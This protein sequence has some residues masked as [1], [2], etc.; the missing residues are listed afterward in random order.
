MVEKAA[1][2]I[3]RGGH[4][5]ETWFTPVHWLTLCIVGSLVPSGLLGFFGSRRNVGSAP[6]SRFAQ[7]L[8][9]TRRCFGSLIPLGYRTTVSVLTHHSADAHHGWFSLVR[10]LALPHR[11]N[12]TSWL[13]AYVLVLADFVAVAPAFWFTRQSWLSLRDFGSRTLVGFRSLS[14][15]LAGSLASRVAVGSFGNRGYAPMCWFALLNWLRSPRLVHSLPLASP[16]SSGSR[17]C[18][19]CR[20]SHLVRAPTSATLGRIGSLDYIG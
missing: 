15:V 11:F 18:P 5:Q 12:P 2:C 13:R 17:L 8:W 20:T 16:T 6:Y 7:S 19:G 9:L 1:P 4:A 14:L 10:W 3:A